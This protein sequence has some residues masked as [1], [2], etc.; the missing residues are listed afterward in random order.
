[1]PRHD[2]LRGAYLAARYRIDCGARTIE[3][4][5]GRADA[6]AALAAAGCRVHWQLLTPCNPGSVPLDTAEND[7]RLAAL[8]REL[9]RLG[10]PH[11]PALNRAAD[12]SWPEAGFCLLDADPAAV[13]ALARRYGQHAIV[14]GRIGAAPVLIDL[15]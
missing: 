2:A 9:M 1:M 7:A 13:R 15:R 14:S 6:D 8:R 12:G 11:L 4:R 5:I 3:R 10:W